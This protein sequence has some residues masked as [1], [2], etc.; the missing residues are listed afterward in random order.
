MSRPADLRTNRAG[1]IINL[2]ESRRAIKRTRA[3]NRQCWHNALHAL[4]RCYQGRS[5]ARYVEG[6]AVNTSLGISIEHGWLEVDGQII[7]CTP[8]WAEEGGG[9]G[10][11]AVARFASGDL[12][13]IVAR[14]DWLPVSLSPERKEWRERYATI[15]QRVH[16]EARAFELLTSL[17]SFISL[18]SLFEEGRNP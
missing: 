1:Q 5:D 12:K 18:S 10:Y 2:S 9:S 15:Y 4:R 6:L 16:A 11:F 8:A 17:A 3:R 7:E 13:G 14:R